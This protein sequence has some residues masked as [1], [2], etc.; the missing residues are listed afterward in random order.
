MTRSRDSES[1]SSET[2]S[3][4]AWERAASEAVDWTILLDDDPDNADLHVQFERWRQ[5]DPLHERVWSEASHASNLIAQSDK[6]ALFPEAEWEEEP[7]SSVPRRAHFRLSRRA[8]LAGAVAAALAWIMAPQILLHVQADYVTGVGRQ[9]TVT[10]DD[11]STVRL[12]P[13]S[14]MRVAY[15]DKNRQVTLL[16]GEAYF[17]VARNPARPFNVLAEEATITVLGTG[18]DVRLGES[19]TD[20]A[21]KHGRVRV[22]S[23]KQGRRFAVLEAGQWV[24]MP[25]NG[26][27][28]NGYVSPDLVGGWTGRRIAAVDRPLAE[29]LADLRRYHSGAI[30]LTST[31]LGR[32]SVTGTFNADDP[33]EAAKLIVQPHGGIVRRITPWL[34]VISAS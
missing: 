6:V 19:G 14:A 28:H 3:D 8:I 13:E 12:A 7:T 31:E 30:L 33:V 5:A 18:F 29:V 25:E 2:V 1:V 15:S 27:L 4:E 22:A 17:E 9:R 20:I 16:S 24:H 32:K 10:L 11:G 21:V 23:V 26:A 34:M